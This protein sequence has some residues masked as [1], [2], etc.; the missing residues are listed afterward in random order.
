MKTYIGIDGGITGALAAVHPDETWQLKPV[1]VVDCGKDPLLDVS[2]NFAFIQEVAQRA[3]GLTN[4]VVVFEHAKKN[5]IFGA[6]G[7][8]ANGRHTEFWRVLL[9]F[10]GI[11]FAWVD[12]NTW[13]ADVF[14]GIAGADT[15]T[16]ARLYIEQRYPAVKLEEFKSRSQ[17]EG[18]RD[19]MCIATWARSALK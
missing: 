17:L 14:R 4:L 9:T 7:N 12:P 18:L 19:A 10:A 15:K 13:Q 8:F 1:A 3:G 11:S 2:A 6:K 16:K 5:P